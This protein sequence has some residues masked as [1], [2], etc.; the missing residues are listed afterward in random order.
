MAMPLRMAHAAETWSPFELAVPFDH[1]HSNSQDVEAA[2]PPSELFAR[3][4]DLIDA[5]IARGAPTRAGVVQL[6]RI[7]RDYLESQR[8]NV[9][10]SSIIGSLSN[11]IMQMLDDSVAQAPAVQVGDW[12]PQSPLQRELLIE[13]ELLM[14]ELWL[15]GEVA[16]E[17]QHPVDDSELQR[18]GRDAIQDSTSETQGPVA[19]Q[20]PMPGRL[21]NNCMT[22]STGQEVRTPS[23]SNT[24]MWLANQQAA[25]TVSHAEV[26][27]IPDA[28]AA[29]L[30]LSLT[31]G[32]EPPSVELW[33]LR[34]LL[35]IRDRVSQ[36]VQQLHRPKQMKLRPCA[37]AAA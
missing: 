35:S 5:A 24:R 7:Q 23:A 25:T 2:W 30:W 37:A 10:L 6:E 27:E 34:Q 21:V 15:T 33:Q 28:I 29:A 1:H 17:L 26:E 18:N 32:G 20:V 11:S 9:L 8:Q 13:L 19:S 12:A 16:Q 4:P 31:E 3:F 36:T 14:D 22:L